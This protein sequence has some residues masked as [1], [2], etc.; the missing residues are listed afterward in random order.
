MSASSS[1]GGLSYPV[2][3]NIRGVPAD[4]VLLE[5]LLDEGDELKQGP[6]FF[7]LKDGRFCHMY[8]DGN[9]S[10]VSDGQWHERGYRYA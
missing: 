2:P 10:V 7:D 6:G 9:E 8:V 1:D 4:K 5:A 3:D